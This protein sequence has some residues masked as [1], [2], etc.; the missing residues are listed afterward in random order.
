MA[1]GTRRHSHRPDQL[2]R[3]NWNFD[4]LGNRHVGP[5]ESTLLPRLGVNIDLLVV[6]T[7]MVA[8]G[9]GTPLLVVTV[10]DISTKENTKLWEMFRAG[11]CLR[12]FQVS[13]LVENNR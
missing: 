7:F 6:D 10:L 2:L 8:I 12:G 1:W 11:N 13:N 4:L 9:N 3:S 5:I